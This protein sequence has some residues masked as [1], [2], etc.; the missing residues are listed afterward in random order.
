MKKILTATL[1]GL[2]LMILAGCSSTPEG[3]MAIKDLAQNIE[4]MIGQKVVVVGTVD[5]KVQGM[6]T[7]GLFKVYKGNVSVWASRPEGSSEPPQAVLVRV[8][9]VVQ[10]EDFPGGIGR[11]VFIQSESVT[12]E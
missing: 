5:T 10:E 4:Q 2:S 8:S 11:R 7:A 1:F 6:A 3:T 12:M 9:G